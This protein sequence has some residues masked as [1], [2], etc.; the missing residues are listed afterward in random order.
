M[1]NNDLSSIYALKIFLHKKIKIKNLGPLRFVLGLEVAKNS[2][3]ITLCQ[4][5]YALNIL[6]NVGFLGAKLVKT[7]LEHNHK[8]STSTGTSLIGCFVY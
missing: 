2:K 4:R 1:T 3:I 8:L 6:E 5:K 7:P